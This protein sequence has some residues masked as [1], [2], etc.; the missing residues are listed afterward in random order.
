MGLAIGFWIIVVLVLL[1]IDWE[2]EEEWDDTY[3]DHSEE[4]PGE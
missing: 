1:A 3:Y 4:L 2:E